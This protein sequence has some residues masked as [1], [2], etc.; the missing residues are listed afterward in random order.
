MTVE[1]AEV[2]R[3]S[4]TL[5]IVHL[6]VSD[7]KIVVAVPFP[8]G[9]PLAHR[10]SPQRYPTSSTP[11]NKQQEPP[12]SRCQRKWLILIC[13]M[14]IRRTEGFKEYAV[15][16]ERSERK[17]GVE[18][19]KES[20]WWKGDE[21][22]DRGTSVVIGAERRSMNPGWSA[23]WSVAAGWCWPRKWMVVMSVR[24]ERRSSACTT[25]TM[26]KD[27]Y[28]ANLWHVILP[29]AKASPRTLQEWHGIKWRT[30]VGQT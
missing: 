30:G 12:P 6:L 22:P 28:V 13:G 17:A 8:V 21:S 4:F 11:R 5:V 29:I 10:R 1:G 26:Y 25:G 24:Q 15:R 18:P 3:T 7:I 20:D 27:G 9:D 16:D 19:R 2:C 14:I 23:D